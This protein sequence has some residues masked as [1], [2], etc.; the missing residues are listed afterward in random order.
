ML[1]LLGTSGVS[2]RVET[3]MSAHAS[4]IGEYKVTRTRRRTRVPDG[5]ANLLV[6]SNH[7]ACGLTLRY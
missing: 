5:E 6:R 4:F 3:R 7:L 1:R 2:R